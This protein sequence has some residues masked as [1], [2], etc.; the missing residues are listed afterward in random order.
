MKLG[1]NFTCH[2]LITDTYSYLLVNCS[3]CSL[4]SLFLFALGV[5]ACSGS[6]DVWASLIIGVIVG[7]MSCVVS[8]SVKKYKPSW[9]TYSSGRHDIT[10]V[11]GVPGILAAVTGI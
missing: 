9:T 10:Y 7:S 2:R 3:R 5:S 1:N 8:L 4:T 6:I 11:H